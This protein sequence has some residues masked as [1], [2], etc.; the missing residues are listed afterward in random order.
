MDTSADILFIFTYRWLYKIL[1]HGVKSY[2]Q[3]DKKTKRRIEQAAKW[4][5]Y[6]KHLFDEKIKWQI[7][8]E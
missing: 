6:H 3:D 4:V 8:K 1:P 2:T 7:S 5:I